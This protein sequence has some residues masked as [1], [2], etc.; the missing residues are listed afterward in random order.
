MIFFNFQ[1]KIRYKYLSLRITYR[2]E[3]KILLLSFFLIKGVNKINRIYFIFDYNKSN[4][5]KCVLKKYK[6]LKLCYLYLKIEI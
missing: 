6:S 2:I 4:C 3:N 1:S 5:T